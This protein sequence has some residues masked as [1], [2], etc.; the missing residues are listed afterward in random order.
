M[1]HEPRDFQV[2]GHAAIRAAAME[3]HTKIVAVAPTGA[4]KTVQ[5]IMLIEACVKKGKRAMFIAHREELIAQICAALAFNE[6][7]HGR[8]Q[9]RHSY[10][11]DSPVIVASIQ[12]L[13]SR[14]MCPSCKAVKKE[15][16]AP[17]CESCKGT[18]KVRSRALP[19]VELIVLDETHRV[20]SPS[21]TDLIETY[22]QARIV[23]LTATPWRLDGR[24][25]GSMFT[26]IVVIAE[27]Q[28]LIDQGWLLPLKIFAPDMPDL[29][30]V[31]ISAGDYAAEELDKRL[32]SDAKR[33]GKV[34]ENWKRLA[35]GLKT[36]AFCA[37]VRD[38]LEVA[39]RFNEAG[40]P[41]EHVDGS[42][43]K[44]KRKAAFEKLAS[45]EITVLCN[46]DIC[47]EGWDMPSL[48]A[49]IL[50][51]P[52][53]S[54]TRV[55]QCIGRVMRLHE[56]MTHG[57]V[58]D[59]AGS[60]L[61]HGEPTE[62]RNWSLE[63]RKKAK[64]E[65]NVPIPLVSCDKCGALRAASKEKCSFCDAKQ[66]QLFRGVV[67]EVDGDLVPYEKI[68]KYTCQGCRGTKVTLRKTSIF[69]YQV[70]CRDCGKSSYVVNRHAAQ[71]AGINEKRQEL[72]RLKKLAAVK[73]FDP[74]FVERQYYEIFRESPQ[75]LDKPQP[76]FLKG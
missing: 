20:L 54:L 56:G 23:G 27:M 28:Q 9:G 26:S 12:T 13:A 59:H 55:M 4:G 73:K 18:G 31:S 69:Q 40:I 7:Q 22:P 10:G 42:T 5:A 53:K 60:I 49:V 46:V 29:S 41:A 75:A 35:P 15:D 11:L 57:I 33:V 63:D 25:L 45:G 6:I 47:T 51:R 1:K 19:D 34:V 66:A 70:K 43:P 50:L 58:L 30:G 65:E 64:E 61:E 16:D 44:M 36:V 68:Q 21:Y 48:G 62:T 76:W 72:A 8:L 38:S 71:T 2:R 39:S 37:S 52:T 17:A 24:G 14:K 3:G 67:S 74:R 32:G